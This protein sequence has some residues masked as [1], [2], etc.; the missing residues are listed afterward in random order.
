MEKTKTE[1]L[2]THKQEKAKHDGETWLYS[3]KKES[4]ESLQCLKFSKNWNSLEGLELL[5]FMLFCTACKDT[6][7]WKP[8][9]AWIPPIPWIPKT[10]KPLQFNERLVYLGLLISSEQIIAVDCW[11][12]W[13][14]SKSLE[15][16]VFCKTLRFL[17]CSDRLESWISVFFQNYHGSRSLEMPQTAFKC[18]EG[19][20]SLECLEF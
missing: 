16:L 18:Y 12:P 7:A 19:L 17:K 15:F 11:Y 14:S 2:G 3:G 1:F 5:E 10:L 20:E 9:N 8:W 6:K 4:L 13:N